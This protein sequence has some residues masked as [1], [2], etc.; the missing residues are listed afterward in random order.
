MTNLVDAA[1]YSPRLQQ[2]W[3]QLVAA[4]CDA[5]NA[6][7]SALARNAYVVTFLVVQRMWHRNIGRRNGTAAA[8]RG[9]R[10]I[11]AGRC[12]ARLAVGGA[13]PKKGTLHSRQVR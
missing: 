8:A 12:V 10:S 9:A 3:Q 5:W 6:D 4:A 1:T 2:S 13:C 11:A 7:G